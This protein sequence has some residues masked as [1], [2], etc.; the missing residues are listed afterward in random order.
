MSILTNLDEDLVFGFIYILLGYP[1]RDLEKFPVA[2]FK[3]IQVEYIA[4][5]ILTHD[6]TYKCLILLQRSDVRDHQR[7]LLY[8][9]ET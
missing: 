3:V 8:F 4:V 1:Y 6:L 9:L 7:N 2:G 5:D